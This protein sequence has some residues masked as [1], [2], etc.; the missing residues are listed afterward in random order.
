M[1][2]G[3]VALYYNDIS[4]RISVEIKNQADMYDL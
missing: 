1:Y 2:K 3:S 4:N